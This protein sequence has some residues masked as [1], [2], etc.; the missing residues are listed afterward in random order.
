MEKMKRLLSGFLALVLVLGMMPGVSITAGA[1]ELETQPETVAVETTQETT[2]PEETA[3]PETAAVTEPAETAAPETAPIQT[4]AEET[5]PQETA[6]EETLPAQTIPAET[7][8]EETVAA[9]TIPGETV[10]E[11][12]ASADAADAAYE[13]IIPVKEIKVVAEK[14]RTYLGDRV[15]LTV[16]IT[17][18]DATETE[19]AWVVDGAEVIAVEDG[20]LITSST[21]GIAEVTAVVKDL[22]KE[23]TYV[24]SEPVYVT[25]LEYWM[26]INLL[27]LAEENRFEEDDPQYNSATTCL[28]KSGETLKLSAKYLTRLLEEDK[29]GQDRDYIVERLSDPDITWSLS[30]GAEQ[31]V[32]M[33][34]SGTSVTLKTKVV[35]KTYIVTLTAKDRIAGEHSVQVVIYPEPYKVTVTPGE[36]PYGMTME[37]DTI[38]VDLTKIKDDEDPEKPVEVEVELTAKI[39]PKEAD[40]NYPQKVVQNLT[41]ESSDN[42]VKL[43]DPDEEDE[44]NQ[45][46]LMTVPNYQ[47]TTTITITSEDDPAIKATLKVRRLR[48]MDKENLSISL[49]SSKVTEL[50]AG[51]RET[52]TAIDIRDKE[53]LTDDVIEWSLP[54]E[55]DHPYASI[56]KAGKLTV[57]DIAVGKVVTLRCAI[58]GHPA[59]DEQW[60]EWPVTVRPKATKVEILPGDLATETNPE[61]V[62]VNGKTLYI[63]TV[64][65]VAPFLLD[66]QVFALDGEE[67]GARQEVKWTSGN[68]AIATVDPD[69]DEICWEG[70]NGTVTITA[71]AADGSGKKATVK[72]NFRLQ[73]TD[74]EIILPG[75]DSV[76]SGS[77]LPLDIKLAPAKVDEATG[78]SG[79]TWKIVSCDHCGEKAACAKISTSGKIT[80]KSVY[81]NHTLLV[82]A[83]TKDGSELTAYTEI[84][85]MPKK[86]GILILKADDEY[87]TKTTQMVD[88]GDSISLEAYTLNYE[89]DQE[90]VTWKSSNKKVASVDEDGNVEVLA[91]G[92][93]T[94]T[95]TAGDDRKAT[96]TIKGVRM[97]AEVLVTHA[98][99]QEA[100]ASGK[101]MTLKAKPVDDEEKTATIKK[102]KWTLEGEGAEFASITSTGK[103][104][105]DKYYV[106]DPVEVTVVATATD[107]SGVRGEYTVLI[108]ASA[109]GVRIDLDSFER[110]RT[111]CLYRLGTSPAEL[112]LSAQV[113][114]E[115]AAQD[116]RW[117]SS[118]KSIAEVDAETGA[119]IVKKA[120]TVTITATANDGS[121]KKSSFKLKIVREAADI[122]FSNVNFLPSGDL[123]IAGGER[124]TLKPTLWDAD[125][126]KLS[127]RKLI[128]SIADYEGDADNGLG[129]ASLSSKGILKTEK[130]SEMKQVVI[131]VKTVE[132]SENWEPLELSFNAFIYPATTSVEVVRNV[133][134]VPTEVE[135]T[136]YVKKGAALDLDAVSYSTGN[137]TEAAQAWVWKTSNKKVAVVDED[138]VVT[139][140][141]AGTVTITVTAKDGTG[142]KDTVKVVVKP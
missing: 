33:D 115:S 119:L 34:A 10:A 124:V 43:T 75:M 24:S 62:A 103:L 133:S 57:K 139:G 77:S 40:E 22:T 21:P 99:D 129:Y 54:Y 117:K 104:T 111:S 52:F 36:L 134:G 71:T 46:M 113:Y 4:E 132:E 88:V 131:T 84:A 30:E 105:A 19:V 125:E 118:S 50:I 68:K 14:T 38:T 85:V 53:I 16:D 18:K 123:V 6:V 94:I 80:A 8:A 25:F 28:V 136:L 20:I 37:G 142:E 81:E 74:I 87:V 107:G 90:Y 64:N 31:F 100:L 122:T 9:E 120:G 92:T 69:T 23:D 66:F 2:I 1:E 48:L 128:W 61:D 121:G 70:K 67:I 83:T 26:E 27:P 51:E 72:L 112:T 96:V 5:V 73:A 106:G 93:A 89:D 59:E 35:T 41:W 3:A 82:S 102:V 140:L 79:V 108:C 42:V 78:K 91:A 13:E 135:T 101:S 60:I 141:K 56:T 11:L 76:R 97:A 127:G 98:K 130:V 109:Q 126:N 12:D 95:A 7:V 116:V 110:T 63:N 137:T 32:T 49:A 44:K 15:K 45:V 55:E 17:P 47:G 138:G 86:D 58:I 39:N 29:A 114:P 65:D